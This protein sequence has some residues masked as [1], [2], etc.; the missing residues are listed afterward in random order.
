VLQK[1]SGFG[2]L[3]GADIFTASVGGVKL[4]EPAADL[5]VALAMVS[6]AQDRGVPPDLIAL[7]E[8]GLTG[9]IRSV[10]GIERRLAAAARLGFR[11]ALVPRL[12]GLIPEG[13]TVIEATD[14]NAAIANMYDG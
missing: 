1:R 5:A 2:M 7:G 4:H 8:V 6:S 9:E 13:M 10:S 11:R 12:S 3:G 14:L